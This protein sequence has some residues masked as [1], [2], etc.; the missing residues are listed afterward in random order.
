MNFADI[1]SAWRSPHN[2][3]NPGQVEKLQARLSDE[4]ERRRR[5][6]RGLLW[7]TA[8][9]L[10][11]V[12]GKLVLHALWPEPGADPVDFTRE[13]VVIP[14][15]FLPWV[16]WLVMW[17]LQRRHEAR[18]ADYARSIRAGLIASLDENR[19]EAVRAGVISALLLLS[20]PLIGG[21]VWQLRA[22]GKA[23]DEILLPAFVAYPTYVVLMLA[24]IAWQYFRKTQ[25]RGRELAALLAEYRD[26]A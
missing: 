17:Q 6:V 4:L 19:R 26:V 21:V 8:I 3:P 12:T 22:V 10:V 5:S 13:W 7:L 23:G 1:E 9:P 2:R 15:F 18:H 16:G 20:V 24:G 11:V 14:F 25:P